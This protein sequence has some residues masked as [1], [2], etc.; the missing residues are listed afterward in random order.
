MHT[1]THTNARIDI[2]DIHTYRIDTN[3]VREIV[4]ARGRRSKN[5]GFR[6][7][8]RRTTGYIQFCAALTSKKIVF[9]TVEFRKSRV[10]RPGHPRCLQ[11]RQ[12]WGLRWLINV[13]PVL[14]R[15]ITRTSITRDHP[16][17]SNG[18]ACLSGSEQVKFRF[19]SQKIKGYFET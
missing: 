18:N 6:F 17:A 8:S 2:N 7:C 15:K 13:D 10:R 1:L 9:V 4:F 19:C 14:A 11:R 5:R 12:N 3:Y 16:G